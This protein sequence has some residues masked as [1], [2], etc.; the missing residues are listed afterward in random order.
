MVD[1]ILPLAL[2]VYVM[3]YNRMASV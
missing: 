2:C 3:E 1:N